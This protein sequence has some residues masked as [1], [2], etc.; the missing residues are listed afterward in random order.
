MPCHR[1]NALKC[2]TLIGPHPLQRIR[3]H[4]H[5]SSTHPLILLPCSD[6]AQCRSLPVLPTPRPHSRSCP[7]L[8]LTLLPAPCS[9]LLLP[10]DPSLPSHGVIT[11]SVSRI[12][13]RS[14]AWRVLLGPAAGE[15][16]GERWL[17]AA[18]G[19]LEGMAAGGA[20]SSRGTTA[21]GVR[22][23]RWYGRRREGL[24]ASGVRTSWRRRENIAMARPAMR[25]HREGDNMWWLRCAFFYCFE[26]CSPSMLSCTRW[27]GLPSVP[28]MPLGV[29]GV[30]EYLF[31]EWKTPSVLWVLPSVPGT[32][33][34]SRF[35]YENITE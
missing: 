17:A 21:S 1:S 19:P 33:R 26:K 35:L 9:P 7:L 20:R 28:R 27:K 22:A 4:P 23:S 14:G 34:L 12:T 18:R 3:P 10:P 8:G 15:P 31:A 11:S 29:Y 16:P 24:S 13:E 25:R 30:A 6:P 5:P 2:S 32:R